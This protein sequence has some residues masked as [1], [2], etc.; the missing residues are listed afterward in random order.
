MKTHIS[1]RLLAGLVPC[2]CFY[3]L[4]LAAQA[5]K[6][7]MYVV[8]C[9]VVNPSMEAKYYQ[10][11][12]EQLALFD[13]YDWPYTWSVYGTNDYCY[14]YMMPVK[15][16]TDVGKLLN[17]FADV[18]AKGGAE[19][20]TMYGKYVGAIQS[21]SMFVLTSAPELS[22]VPTSPRL[23]PGEG[24]IVILDIWYATVGKEEEFE[25]HTKQV[26]A[27]A[28]KRNITSAWNAFVGGLGTEQPVYVFAARDTTMVSFWAANA[29]MWKALGKEGSTIMDQ[30]QGCTRKRE[31]KFAWYQPG[32]G[33]APKEKRQPK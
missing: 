18:A 23:K 28:E 24:N 7:Q 29:D 22:Y 25:N 21:S 13:K 10:T 27:L 14:Y 26:F 5:P 33:Y 11:V 1:A 6:S 9:D 31:W 30:M 8:G 16:F 12:K 15:D 2:L 17:A 3:S 32:L 4:P 20:K 19:W